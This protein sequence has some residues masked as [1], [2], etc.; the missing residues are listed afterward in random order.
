MDARLCARVVMR[1]DAGEGDVGG[2]A[3]AVRGE[4]AGRRPGAKT[5]AAAESRVDD[6]SEDGGARKNSMVHY[7]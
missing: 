7:S 4:D 3:N 6:A 5:R 2:T 1:A